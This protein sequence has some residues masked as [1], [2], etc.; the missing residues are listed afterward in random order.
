MVGLAVVA[1]AY[2]SVPQHNIQLAENRG[3]WIIHKAHSLTGFKAMSSHFLGTNL[4]MTQNWEEWLICQRVVLPSRGTSTDWRTEL[5]DTRLNMSQQCTL[6]AKKANG[7]LGCIRRS[8]ASRS[9]EVILPL[10]SA[11]VRPHLESCV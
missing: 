4:L 5:V 11:L 2:Q 7:I 6:A 8:V 1:L 9:R 10:Y 3:Q